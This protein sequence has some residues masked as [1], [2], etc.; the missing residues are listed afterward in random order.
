[1][2]ALGGSTFTGWR[3]PYL[4]GSAQLVRV[5]VAD[6][7]RAHVDLVESG[8]YGMTQVQRD[9]RRLYAVDTRDSFG[10]GPVDLHRYDLLA[11][12]RLRARG[13]VTL[14]GPVVDLVVRGGVAYVLQSAEPQ[15]ALV[16]IDLE[17]WPAV[18]EVGRVP[19]PG[20]AAL[21]AMADGRAYVLMHPAAGA[22]GALATIDLED[23]LAPR[24]AGQGTVPVGRCSAMAANGTRLWLLDIEASRLVEVDA[25]IPALPA[26]VHSVQVHGGRDLAVSD[27]LAF[28]LG[29]YPPS[30]VAFELSPDGAPRR[31]GALDIDVPYDGSGAPSILAD[32]DLVFVAWKHLTAVDAADPMD[33]R[34]VGMLSPLDYAFS[35][36]NLVGY[37]TGAAAEGFLYLGVGGSDVGDPVSS[38]GIAVVRLE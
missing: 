14:S 4:P 24:V 23:G 12:G 21:L 37:V 31:R 9:G 2:W 33:L 8:P 15:S 29:G 18:R 30:L 28:V 13:S 5:N 10:P 38:H 32:G 17:D 27:D 35:E 36:W 20:Q 34:Q 22:P 26:V 7:R 6:P 11:P 25:A 16:T 19:L 1:M 3:R